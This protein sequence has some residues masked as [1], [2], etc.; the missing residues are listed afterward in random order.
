MDTSLNKNE[1][2]RLR[3][4]TISVQMDSLLTKS[5]RS[6]NIYREK[7]PWEFLKNPVK[8]TNYYDL[9]NANYTKQDDLKEQFDHWYAGKYHPVLKQEFVIPEKN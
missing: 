2:F 6:N 4:S 3:L 9:L 1:N 7:S 5:I 8:L